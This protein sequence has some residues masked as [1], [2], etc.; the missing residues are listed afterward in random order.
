MKDFS[1]RGAEAQ[2]PVLCFK[3]RKGI[4]QCRLDMFNSEGIIVVML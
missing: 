3:E 2:F 4:S 1:Q